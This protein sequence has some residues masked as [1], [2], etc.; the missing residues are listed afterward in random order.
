MPRR[1]GTGRRLLKTLPIVFWAV[2]AVAAVGDLATKHIVFRLFPNRFPEAVAAA[3]HN[4]QAARDA[5][6]GEM[7]AIGRPELARDVEHADFAELAERADR[8]GI[9]LLAKDMR[10]AAL[11]EPAYPPL[12]IIDGFLTIVHSRNSG[13]VFGLWKGSRAWLLFGLAAGGLVL[14]FAHRDDSRT[15]L[16]QIALGLIMAGAIGNVYDRLTFGFVR[17]F[18]DVCYWSGK[19]WPAFNVADSGICVGA[20]YILVHGLFFIPKDKPKKKDG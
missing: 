3:D 11:I 7:D 5:F 18:I 9:P 17:D 20:A 14:W 13:G 10:E 15:V 8:A 1:A 4:R 19:H 2:T 6:A 16:L 12:I